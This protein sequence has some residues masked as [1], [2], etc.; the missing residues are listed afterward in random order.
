[1]RFPDAF[2]LLSFWRRR[3]ITAATPGKTLGSVMDVNSQAVLFDTANPADKEFVE[4]VWFE[5][6]NS[7]R[8]RMR[9]TA[10]IHSVRLAGRG[11]N[12]GF[13]LF[14]FLCG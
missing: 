2:S 9:S 6:S 11:F 8:V 5:K 7:I 3:S 14:Q 13:R 12:L 10:R 1:M 4:N